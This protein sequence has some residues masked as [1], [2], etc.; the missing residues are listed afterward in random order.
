MGILLQI[1][2]GK[3]GSRLKEE[4]RAKRPAIGGSGPLVS[5]QI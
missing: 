2:E 3:S 5:V 4:C 1:T